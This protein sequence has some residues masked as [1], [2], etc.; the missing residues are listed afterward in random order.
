[1][2]PEQIKQALDKKGYSLSIL[3]AALGLNLS[4]VSSVVY[5]HTTSYKVA[6]AIAKIIDE[7]VEVIFPDVPAY[8]KNKDTRSQ[9]VQALRELLA[10]NQ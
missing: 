9:K 1:M 10:S 7:P 8:V 6:A 3:A 2:K 5:Q 4:H